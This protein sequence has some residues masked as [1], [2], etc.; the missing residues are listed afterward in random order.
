MFDIG[1]VCARYYSVGG[2]GSADEHG[3]DD[4]ETEGQR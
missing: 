2:L 4:D 3:G 1:D